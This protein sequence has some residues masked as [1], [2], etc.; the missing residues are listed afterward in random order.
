MSWDE[1][2]TVL[3][4][5][6]LRW[7]QDQGA[8]RE[9][10]ARG[11]GLG[12]ARQLFALCAKNAHLRLG[13]KLYVLTVVVILPAL[14]VGA[15]ALIDRTTN[16]APVVEANAEDFFSL[17]YAPASALIECAVFEPLRGSKIGGAW[18]SPMLFAPVRNGAVLDTMRE[19][20]GRNGWTARVLSGDEAAR[21]DLQIG[22]AHV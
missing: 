1:G 9:V 19:V 10:Q 18:C 13:R 16:T 15:L 14:A 2:E 17:G 4:R 3:N 21:A 5:S 12:F 11:F 20:A 22:R 6:K 8:S 7:L